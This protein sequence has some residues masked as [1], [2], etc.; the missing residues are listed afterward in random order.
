MPGQPNAKR[1]AGKARGQ[2]AAEERAKVMS[3]MAAESAKIAGGTKE[4]PVT[5]DLASNPVWQ[6]YE[7]RRQANLARMQAE[8]EAWKEAEKNPATVEQTQRAIA[9]MANG[10]TVREA[11]ELL[12]YSYPAINKTMYRSEELRQAADHAREQYA[13]ERVRRMH[14]IIRDEP[15][16]ARARVLA[17]AIKWE[18]SKVLP[19]FYGDKL[20]VG[21]NDKAVFSIN[22]GTS[23]SK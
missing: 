8:G 4:Q 13:H 6:A 15:D 14:E 9:L 5:A 11:C 12:G 19:K 21:I 16:A 10:Y 23:P 17:D 3:E 20:D 18:V 1:N 7:E 2:K 22:L